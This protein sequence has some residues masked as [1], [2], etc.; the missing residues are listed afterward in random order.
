MK[1]DI[2]VHFVRVEGLAQEPIKTVLLQVIVHIVIDCCGEGNGGD[3]LIDLA[4]VRQQ[5]LAI[6][7]WHFQIDEQDVETALL[8]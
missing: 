5:G 8:E 3:L 1:H 7:K 6:H 2:A 4:Y